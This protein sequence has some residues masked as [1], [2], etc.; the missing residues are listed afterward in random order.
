MYRELGITYSRE[1]KFEQ[2]AQIWER[3]V[4]AE[5]QFAMNYSHLAKFYSQTSEQLWTILYGETYILLSEYSIMSRDIGRLVMAAYRQGIRVFSDSTRKVQLTSE[6]KVFVNAGQTH[7]NFEM[8]LQSNHAAAAAKV[9]RGRAHTKPINVFELT[10]MRRLFLDYWF[11]QNL[12]QRF[13]CALLDYW[14]QLDQAGLLEAYVIKEL[15]YT[16]PRAHRELMTVNRSAIERYDAW[17]AHH[18]LTLNS[19]TATWNGRFSTP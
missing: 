10:D 5:P 9:L 16:D 14:L 13:P 18:P 6:G 12:Q 4:A 19:S 1:L 2:A 11:S 15:G 8:A 7:P 3:G 17:R